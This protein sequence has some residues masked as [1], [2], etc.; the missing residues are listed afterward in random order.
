MNIEITELLN[1]AT[2]I[3]IY[4]HANCTDGFGAAF[5]IEDFLDKRNK[6]TVPDRR[7]TAKFI[8]AVYNE[9]TIFSTD[10]EDR[11][12]FVVDF[13]FKPETMFELCKQ[14]KAVVWIDHHVG[15]IENYQDYICKE[16]T[17]V[18]EN[19]FKYTSLKCSGAL[20][21]WAYLWGYESDD[22][23]SHYRAIPNLF[24]YISDRD[25]WKFEL[26]QSKV[27]T[28]YIS[29]INFGFD[30]FR[31]LQTKLHTESGI[32]DAAKIG[33]ILLD[34][35]DIQINKILN[36]SYLILEL[37]SEDSYVPVAVCNCPPNFASD[38]GNALFSKY[39]QAQYSLTWHFNG[40]KYLVSLR[41]T[42]GRFDVCK[43]AKRY[44]GGGHR[45]AAGYS[46]SNADYLNF[47]NCARRVKLNDTD[48]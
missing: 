6:V 15:A 23:L 29:T 25:I 41:S 9:T 14:A 1:N 17:I 24:K 11:L 30:D 31:N 19:F 37:V 36:T 12:V 39:P 47:L 40:D 18:P 32:M 45:N 7:I 10:I 27:V 42:E 13:S 22:D 34:A 16:D 28:E 44:G 48:E 26:Y 38:V 3:T 4:Y 21:T 46:L 2:P 33:H 43:I 5:A 8:P 20:L 35:K